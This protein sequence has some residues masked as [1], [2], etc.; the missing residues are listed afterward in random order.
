MHLL[1]GQ[2]FYY[3]HFLSVC[4]EVFESFFD[5]FE[6]FYHFVRC[7]QKAAFLPPF[8]VLLLIVGRAPRRRLQEEP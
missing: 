3:T 6:Y 4:Q 8:L 1:I 5:F 2:L 7:V